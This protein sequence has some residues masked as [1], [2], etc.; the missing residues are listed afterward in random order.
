M[1]RTEIRDRI[2]LATLPHV[3]FD[4][5]SDRALAAGLE[6]AGLP[7][8]M[9]VR[10][11]PGGMRE[12][13]GHWSNYGDRRMADAAQ[14]RDLAS[15]RIR[16]RIAAVVRLRIEV[17]L[18]HREA[19]RR[20]LSFLALPQ[21]AEVAARCTYDTVNA[22]WYAVGDTS[23]DY[24]FYTKRALLAAVYGATVLYWLDDESENFGDTWS[25]LDRRIDGAMKL[26]KLQSRLTNAIQN[27]AAP[28][29]G[30]VRRSF[31]GRRPI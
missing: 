31:R 23:S 6:V 16:D 22:M 19:A 17:D 30:R 7:P 2:V 29:R 25:F 12:V 4:G 24:T 1:D 27:L 20:A 9:A 15:L 28:V 10:I 14:A 26:P 8:D 11:F 18:V 5:W 21:N 13:V 3:A